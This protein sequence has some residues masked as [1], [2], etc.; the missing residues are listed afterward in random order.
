MLRY[1]RL[2]FSS[3]QLVVWLV[4]SFVTGTIAVCLIG[5]VLG[6]L[7]PIAMNHTARIVPRELV[8][9]CIGWI[10]ACGAAGS[11]LLPLWTGEIASLYGIGGLQPL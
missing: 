2:H 11:A 10:A 7:Y 6:P 3:L 5:I 9:G 4:P 8:T 1:P